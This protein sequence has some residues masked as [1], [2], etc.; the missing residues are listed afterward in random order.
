MKT[1]FAYVCIPPQYA[2]IENNLQSL[3]QS[4]LN[5]FRS[6]PEYKKQWAFNENT[7]EGYADREEGSNP[8]AI[9][10]FFFRPQHPLGPFKKELAS[11]TA[12]YQVFHDEIALPLLARIFSEAQLAEHYPEISQATFPSFSFAYYPERKEKNSPDPLK[13]HKDFDMITVLWITKPGLEMFFD[14][15][16]HQ[17][18]P[19]PG[20]LAVN[21]GNTLEIMTNKRAS[22][23]LHRVSLFSGE[24]LSLGI[25]VGPGGPIKD[26]TSKQVIY[27]SYHAYLSTQFKGLYETPES[28]NFRP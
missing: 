15:S 26:F 8:Q 11:I 20:Y 22:S 4:G 9:K 18:D 5:F 14:Q 21:L 3:H 16:W 28:Q 1:G 2:S 13:A 10:Q 25:F 19:K 12:I 27:P 23:V 6:K 7:M 24:R 17:V